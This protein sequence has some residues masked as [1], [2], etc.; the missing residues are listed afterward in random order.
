MTVCSGQSRGT[1]G[2]EIQCLFAVQGSVLFGSTIFV[3]KARLKVKTICLA[4]C[5]AI[6]EY[7]LLVVNR[8]KKKTVPLIIVNFY[9]TLTV[10]TDFSDTTN[11]MIIS[12]SLYIA[13]CHFQLKVSFFVSP[14]LYF[15]LNGAFTLAFVC[16]LKFTERS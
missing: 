5:L 10:V 7:H 2:S 13:I 6:L 4:S 12:F 1:F 16:V 15:T 11:L 8:T 14:A 9:F 3:C